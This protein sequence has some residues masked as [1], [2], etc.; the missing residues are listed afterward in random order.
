[1]ALYAREI[2]AHLAAMAGAAGLI[3]LA[4]LFR[5]AANEAADSLQRLAALAVDDD[6]DAAR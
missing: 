4:A 1:M 6:A 2:A 5:A 3:G